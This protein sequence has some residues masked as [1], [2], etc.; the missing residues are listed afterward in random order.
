MAMRWGRVFV[1]M[2]LAATGAKAAVDLGTNNGCN[3]TDAQFKSSVLWTGP[4]PSGAQVPKSNA[5]LKVTF[6]KQADGSVDVYFIQKQGMVKRYNGKSATVDDLGTITVD[7]SNDEY[8]LVGIAAA[9]DFLQKPYLYFQYASNSGGMTTRISRI[10]M[11]ADLSKLDLSSEKVL[12]SIPRA[13]VTWHTA[14]AMQFDDYGDL[15]IAVGDNQQTDQGPGNTAD[16]RGG[17]S[18]IHPD[19]GV[20]NGY[21]IPAGNFADHF[22][23]RGAGYSDT[24][25]VKPQIYVKGTRNAY[26]M[27]VDP[28]R[29]WVGWGDV[30]PDQGKVSEE[31]NLVK[32]PVFAGWPYYAG[33]EDM[34]GISAYG[35]AGAIKAGSTK[36]APVNGAGLGIKTLPPVTDPIFA[37]NQGCAMVGPIIRYDG[38]NTKAGQF[39]PQMNRKWIIGGCDS[40]GWHLVTLNDAG[41]SFAKNEAIWTTLSP[42][43][44]T[45]VDAKQGPDGA[46]YYV[47]YGKG[48]VNKI[49]Y[50]GTCKDP[51]LLPEKVP[52][53]FARTTPS[54]ADWLSFDRRSVSVSAP[55]A[56]HV[57]ILD[58]HGRVIADMSGTGPQSHA[59]PVLP[60]AG[61]YHLRVRASSGEAFATLP[62]MGRL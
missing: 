21:T 53:D 26:T 43:V 18:R 32:E 52:G 13:S 60:A 44:T 27:F 5:V 14:G 24:S 23:S 45:L 51:S 17:I 16:L 33:E 28:V 56:H 12:I 9:R 40:Y 41:T 25:I 31:Y 62:Y 1:L 22:K 57:E 47:D 11:N 59:M 15:W 10:K 20:P 4:V 3:A 35:N 50:T 8:G 49:E 48:T 54:R 7:Y 36:A 55:G 38:T 61:V 37:R 34:T 58:L 29:R 6:V 19:D 30:G 2:G 39:P 42:R 46:L